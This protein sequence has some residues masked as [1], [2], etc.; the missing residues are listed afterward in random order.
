[1]SYKLQVI[2]TIKNH[3][4]IW[5]DFIFDLIFP[6]QCLGCNCEGQWLCQNCR[7]KLELLRSQTCFFCFRESKLGNTCRQC[8]KEHF[9]DGII[10][11][12]FYNDQLLSRLIKYLKYYFIKDIAIILGNITINFWQINILKFPLPLSKTYIIPVPLHQ[13]RL[14]WR[15][16]N[17]SELLA[18]ILAS[19]LNRPLNTDLIRIKRRQPQVK[20]CK[21]KRLKNIKNCFVWK[22]NNQA[23]PYILLI[24]DVATSGATLDECARILKQNGAKKVWALVLARGRC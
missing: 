20:L 9:I 22:S 2:K 6:I 5:R 11:L 10:S 14:R 12:G 13:Q 15:G 19:Y 7:K 18:Q 4:K 23:P 16:F 1:M 3:A 8:Q 24:D 17:Q 21:E